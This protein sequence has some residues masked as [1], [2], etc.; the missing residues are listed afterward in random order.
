MATVD[1]SAA[2]PA[3]KGLYELSRNSLDDLRNHETI[4]GWR[5]FGDA[6]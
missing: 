2:M 6:G 1:N 5:G 3:A 4:C